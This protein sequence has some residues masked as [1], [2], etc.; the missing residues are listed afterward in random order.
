MCTVI[1]AITPAWP[2]LLAANRDEMLARP[3]TPPASHWPDQPDVVGGLDNL[4]GG[5]WLAATRAGLV[6]VV[7][8]RAGS[9]GP[10][11]GKRSRGDLPLLAL[12]HPSA[13]AA[14]KA[15]EGEAS[16]QWRSF[17]LI[18]ADRHAAIFLRGTGHG[19]ITAHPLPPG[20][21]MITAQDPND[22]SSPRVARHL[23]RFQQAAL[24][25]PPGWSDWPAL[26]ADGAGPPEAALRV[27]TPRGFGTVTSTLLALGATSHF[28]TTPGPP[29]RTA[30]APVPAWGEP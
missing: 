9:L 17:N 6:A 3:W 22:L 28:L 16:G 12:R 26:L 8:N 1:L 11:A 14:S 2:L 4:A 25:E 29:D 24:P 19:P 20:L 30:F 27:S 18:V 15:L 23:P 21:H 7:L 13:R 10:E 5:T